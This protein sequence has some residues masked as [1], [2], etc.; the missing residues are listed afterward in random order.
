MKAKDWVDLTSVPLFDD[1]DFIEEERN[2]PNKK[3]ISNPTISME[4]AQ[5]YDKELDVYIPQYLYKRIY[6]FNTIVNGNVVKFDKSFYWFVND[7]TLSQNDILSFYQD[8]YFKQES[9]MVFFG[10]IRGGRPLNTKDEKEPVSERTKFKFCSI[11]IDNEFSSPKEK[12]G[13]WGRNTFKDDDFEKIAS[14]LLESKKDPTTT[15][16]LIDD[17]ELVNYNHKSVLN[18]CQDRIAGR[19]IGSIKDLDDSFTK[20]NNKKN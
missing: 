19:P 1:N 12:I 17:L 3:V 13:I 7:K 8:Y 10:F 9:F 5:I 15:I 6:K 4:M 14:R 18:L 16:K 20:S 11:Y 2:D